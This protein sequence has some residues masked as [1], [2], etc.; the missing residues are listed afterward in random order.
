MASIILPE[1]ISRYQ[2]DITE[3]RVGKSKCD[4]LTVLPRLTPQLEHRRAQ[5]VPRKVTEEET[6]RTR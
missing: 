1:G 3:R 6:G 4:Q 2:H 5:D